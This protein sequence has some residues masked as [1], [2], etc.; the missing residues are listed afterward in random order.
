M[1]QKLKNLLLKNR[2]SRQTFVKNVFW[3]SAANIVNRLIKF[4]LVI[5]AARLLGAAGYGIFSYT[6]GLAALFSLFGDLGVAG[7]ITREIASAPKELLKKYLPAALWTSIFLMIVNTA[8]IIFAAP[9]FA[10]IKEAVPLL[11]IAALLIGFDT[12]RNLAFAVTRAREKMELEAGIDFITNASITVLGITALLWQPNAGTFLFGY[13]LG[14]GIGTF[15][16]AWMLRKHLT[17]FWGRIDFQTIKII[18][19][20]AV[21]A[22]LMGLLG[23]IM[24][25][26]DTII[27]GYFVTA[28]D[29]GLY[30]AAQRPVMALYVIPA[31]LGTAIFPRVAQLAKENKERLQKVLETALTVTFLISLPIFLGGTLLSKDIIQFLFGNEYIAAAHT[32]A[33]LLFTIVLI[34]PQIFLTGG[35]FALNGQKKFVRFLI[36]GSLGNIILD[37]LLIPRYE[38]LGSA[39]AT[40]ITGTVIT[41]LMWREMEKTVVLDVARRLGKIIVS[42]IA[43]ALVTLLLKFSGLHLVLNIVASAGAYFLTLYLLRETMLEE[44]LFPFKRFFGK[45]QL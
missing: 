15:S 17:E 37:L 10:N 33:A 24:L 41:M 20:K 26:T 1:L 6:I 39:I 8:I 36:V 7:L 9:L 45:T 30:S 11:P 19:S 21:P 38:G 27:L 40:V 12:L 44:I 32:F 35:I 5:Y 14:S 18:I 23:P 2:D 43:M 13:A 28:S 16:A 42:A 22:G 34:F 25:H 4:V 29:L 3:L 31:I